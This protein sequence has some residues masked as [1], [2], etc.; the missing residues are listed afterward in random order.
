MKYAI[1][2]LLVAISTPL[3]AHTGHVQEV[4][5]HTHSIS[6]LVLMSAALAVIAIAGTAYSIARAKRLKK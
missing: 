1:A 5:G 3:Y 6:E 2:T 4:A